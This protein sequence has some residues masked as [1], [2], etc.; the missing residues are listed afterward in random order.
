MYSLFILVYLNMRLKWDGNEIEMRSNL[1]ACIK[2][3]VIIIYIIFYIFI[4]LSII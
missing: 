2:H 1:Y 4:L 3:I